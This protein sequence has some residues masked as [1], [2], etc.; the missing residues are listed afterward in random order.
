M[1]RPEG[2]GGLSAAEMYD[3]AL[4]HTEAMDG[5]P[6]ESVSLQGFI[7]MVRIVCSVEGELVSCELTPATDLR[8]PFG[9]DGL[10]AARAA[11]ASHSSRL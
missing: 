8:A 11:L 2:A 10:A 3:M 6:P 4:G 5:T 1:A 7:A 9:R